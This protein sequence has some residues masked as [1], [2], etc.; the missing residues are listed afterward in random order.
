MKLTIREK[1]LQLLENTSISIERQS[2]LFM[3]DDVETIGGTVAIPFELPLTRPNH[4]ILKFIQSFGN[5]RTTKQFKDAVLWHGGNQHLT[6]VLEVEKL[7]RYTAN[8]KIYSGVGVLQD[9]KNYKLNNP[10]LYLPSDYY[11]HTISSMNQVLTGTWDLLFV[12]LYSDGTEY[13]SWDS[14]NQ[15]FISNNNAVPFFSSV[16]L[17]EQLLERQGYTLTWRD[18]EYWRDKLFLVCN[19]LASSVFKSTDILPECTAA[20]FV[21]E[22]AAVTGSAII[23]DAQRKVFRLTKYSA[24][25]KGTSVDWTK[26]VISVNSQDFVN[27]TFEKDLSSHE[28]ETAY[29]QVSIDGGAL[30][31]QQLRPVLD[32]VGG[33]NLTK[34]QF[35]LYRGMQLSNVVQMSAAYNIQN[36]NYPYASTEP[37]GGT[38]TLR[39]KD[40]VSKKYEIWNELLFNTR[41]INIT[42]T[43]NENTLQNFHFTKVVRILNKKDGHTYRFLVKSIKQTLSMNQAEPVE[44]ELLLL[45]SNK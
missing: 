7:N 5:R 8:A 9:F 12:P 23:V 15:T 34:P 27:A 1:E 6:G 41:L 31:L 24:L 19:R 13:N 25:G 26:H 42:A 20:E 36:Y 39:W 3:G 14:D 16:A 38:E 37:I 2:P 40:G 4:A 22:L 32:R 35:L 43:L 17:L 10:A 33:E 45:D 18:K 21:K 29:H 28:F 44:I 30:Q 11:Y